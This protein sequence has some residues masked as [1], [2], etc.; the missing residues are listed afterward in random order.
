MTMVVVTHELE[1]AREIADRVVFMDDGRV[2]EEGESEAVL[3]NPVDPRT[4]E[5]LRLVQ[6]ERV[7]P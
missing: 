4:R 3:G 7:T 2:V 1:F 5:F 6:R